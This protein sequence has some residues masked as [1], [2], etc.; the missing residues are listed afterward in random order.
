MA[1]GRA[2]QDGDTFVNKNGYHHTRVAGE[3]VGTHRLVAAQKLGRPVGKDEYVSFKDGDRT[4]LDP[5]NIVIK[6]LGAASLRKRYAQLVARIDDAIGELE[7]VCKEL[8]EEVP[9]FP[10][11]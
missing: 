4:N 3:W 7:V 1:R 11:A 10:R 9:R 2:A 6:K 8:G 5:G